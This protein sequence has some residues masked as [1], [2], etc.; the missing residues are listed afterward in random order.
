[1]GAF[2]LAKT[3]FATEPWITSKRVLKHLVMP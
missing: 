2:G 1:M 3:S